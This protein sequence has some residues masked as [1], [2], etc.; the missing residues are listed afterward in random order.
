MNQ[1]A[2]LGKKQQKSPIFHTFY[3]HQTNKIELTDS[4]GQK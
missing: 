1:F 4:R 2:K 3:S